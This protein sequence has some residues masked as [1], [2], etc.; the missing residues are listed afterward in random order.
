MLSVLTSN[1]WRAVA[2]TDV[3]LAALVYDEADE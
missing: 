2:E 1:V 3:S